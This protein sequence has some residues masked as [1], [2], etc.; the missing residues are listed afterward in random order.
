MYKIYLILLTKLTCDTNCTLQM[1]EA[2]LKDYDQNLPFC[3]EIFPVTESPDAHTC[4]DSYIIA[5]ELPIG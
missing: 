1:Q 4:N 2:C 5:I 3:S